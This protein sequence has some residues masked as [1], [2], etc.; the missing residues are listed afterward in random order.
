MDLGY[1][2]MTKIKGQHKVPSFFFTS[3]T[4]E[5]KGLVLGLICPNANKS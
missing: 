3:T 5:E 4:D 1:A 2:K